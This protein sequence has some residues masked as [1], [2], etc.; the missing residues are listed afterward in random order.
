[1]TTLFRPVGPKELKLIEA[2]DW[3]KFPPRLFWQ[4]FFYPVLNAQYATEITK[5]NLDEQGS[6][7]VL[8]FDVN[9]EFLK[10]YVIKTVGDRYHQEYWIPADDLD[11]FN[12]NIE[13]TIELIASFESE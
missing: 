1:M 12:E 10:Q 13:G 11:K 5:W 8:R 7:Y 4:S 6:G 3:K 2:L 9:D